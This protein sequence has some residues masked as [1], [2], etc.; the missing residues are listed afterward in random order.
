MSKSG[1]K[2]RPPSER[3]W[4]HV[5]KH[6]PRFGNRGRCWLWTGACDPK[7]YGRFFYAGS[8]T[9][10]TR[11]TILAHRFAYGPVPDGLELD[12][13][14][15]RHACV[16]PSH[17]EPVKHLENVRRGNGGQNTARKTHCPARHPYSGDNLYV[18][19]DGRR[20]C[21]ICLR[22]TKHRYAAKRKAAV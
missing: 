8:W 4:K 7:G 13:L 6:G 14:C 19:S 17:L 3:F 18:D 12:H 10:G 2:P 15:R 1:P 16:R 20:R 21:W 22:A 11:R 5:N 9:D